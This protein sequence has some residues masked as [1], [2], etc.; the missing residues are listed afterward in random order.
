MYGSNTYS[1]A[2][3]SKT[4]FEKTNEGRRYLHSRCISEEFLVERNRVIMT[5][6][7]DKPEIT[8]KDEKQK[9]HTYIDINQTKN[10]KYLFFNAF[11]YILS[12]SRPLDGKDLPITR[13]Y[14]ELYEK[15]KENEDIIFEF[16]KIFNVTIPG[17]FK[18]KNDLPHLGTYVVEFADNNV[19]TCWDVKPYIFNR[20]SIDYVAYFL[21]CMEKDR[22]FKS[23]NDS[24]DVFQNFTFVK[25]KNTTP[26]DFVPKSPKPGRATAPRYEPLA[27]RMKFSSYEEYS[28]D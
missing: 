4:I 8:F 12:S 17:K 15:S 16:S 11:L 27:K 23:Y 25:I 10:S 7:F 28:T 22:D 13:Y 3:I 1:S 19:F 14:R 21:Y 26:L 2:N 18:L 5:K 20:Y 6:L 24:S 9:T